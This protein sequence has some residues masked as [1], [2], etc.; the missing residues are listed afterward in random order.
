MAVAATPFEL[1]ESQRWAIQNVLNG[2][3]FAIL[4]DG[5]ANI[6]D[7]PDITRLQDLY[8]RFYVNE[9]AVLQSFKGKPRHIS[10]PVGRVAV[11]DGAPVVYGAWSSPTIRYVFDPNSADELAKLGRGSLFSAV[12]TLNSINRGALEFTKCRAGQGY[13]NN[14]IEVR[15]SEIM[16]YLAGKPARRAAIPQQAVTLLSLIHSMPANS[17]CLKQPAPDLT[18]FSQLEFQGNSLI[19]PGVREAVTSALRSHGFQF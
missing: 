13:I 3:S 8:Q 12:C 5:K 4:M 7:T 14:H 16:D 6:I 11:E 19:K 18:C 9:L 10:F 2:E 15:R 17:A 1:S